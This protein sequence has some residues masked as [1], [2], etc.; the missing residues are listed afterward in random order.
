MK[1]SVALVLIEHP[2][3]CS[4]NFFDFFDPEPNVFCALS[5]IRREFISCLTVND[6]SVSS[7]SDAAK[8]Y[9]KQAKIRSFS[10]SFA[11]K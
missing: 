3:L 1:G 2:Y 8:P 10:S 9:Q 6:F 5:V 11:S 4:K 7:C